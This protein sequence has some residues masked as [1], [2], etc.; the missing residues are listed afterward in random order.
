MS[1]KIDVNIGERIKQIRGVQ[2]QQVFADLLGIG[3]TTLINYESNMR[4][5]DAEL[6]IKLHVLY[7]VQ[8]L[9]LLTGIGNEVSGVKLKPDEAA[10][11]DNYRHCPPEGK[12]ALKTTSYALAQQNAEYDVKKVS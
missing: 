4:A 3:R 2:T 6:L 9:W 1:E 5:P 11:L 10:L 7:K 8:P 12:A